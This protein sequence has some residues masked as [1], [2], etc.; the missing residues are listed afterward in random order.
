[1]Q[2]QVLEP[3]GVTTMRLGHTLAKDRAKAE[4]AYYTPENDKA[5]AIMGPEIGKLVPEQYGA[6]SLE[7]LD[8]H[9]GWIASAEDLVRFAA[10]FNHPKKCKILG[11]KYIETMF[12]RPEG[13]PGKNKEG[14]PKD[15]YYG[16]GWEVRTFKDGTMNAWHSGS[17]PGTSTLLVRRNDGLTWAALFNS[18]H[19]PGKKDEPAD[20]IDGLLRDAADA[21]EK[22]PK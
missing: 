4:V 19:I 18:R 9:G 11:E 5:K 20:L 15:V 16:C 8:A 2:K 10:A 13:A 21:V 12:A 14:K 22:W 17:L 1:V 3:L 6:W 7:A